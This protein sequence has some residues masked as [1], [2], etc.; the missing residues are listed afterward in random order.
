M[1]RKL[2]IGIG[3]EFRGDDAAG[4]IAADMLRG[5]SIEDVT[6]KTCVREGSA[7][8]LLWDGYHDVVLIDAVMS[9][10]KPGTVTIIDLQSPEVDEQRYRAS[11]HSFS[12]LEAVKLAGYVGNVPQKLRLYA[13]EGSNFSMCI[14]LSPE[15]RAAV[16]AVVEMITAELIP[17]IKDE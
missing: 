10:S 17:T 11:T 9:G 12:I 3:N 14:A 5:K 1:I 13:I 16:H 6:V 7:L 4:L 8:L 15:V 2:I